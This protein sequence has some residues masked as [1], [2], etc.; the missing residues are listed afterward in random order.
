MP[1]DT[2]VGLAE[3]RL[4]LVG[5]VERT[6]VSPMW[7]SWYWQGPQ[8]VGWW[9]SDLVTLLCLSLGM[10]S[11]CTS[12]GTGSPCF[13]RRKTPSWRTVEGVPILRYIRHGGGRVGCHSVG[14]TRNCTSCVLEKWGLLCPY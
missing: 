5:K 9:S 3:D 6:E 10:E 7:W 2:G 14:R 1:I 12:Q 13:Y 11:G 8:K 4:S